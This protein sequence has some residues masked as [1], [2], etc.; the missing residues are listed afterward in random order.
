MQPLHLQRIC[1]FCICVIVICIHCICVIVISIHCIG[2]VWII[3]C[4]Q[5]YESKF[6]ITGIG[7]TGNW[8]YHSR[9]IFPCHWRL[10]PYLVHQ[11]TCYIKRL[12]LWLL[13][14]GLLLLEY[15]LPY[16]KKFYNVCVAENGDDPEPDSIPPFTEYSLEELKVWPS[17]FER[18]LVLDNGPCNSKSTRLIN[19]S[20]QPI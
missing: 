8:I 10:V 9:T 7:F 16:F 13:N 3:F 5:L 4:T 11:I 14:T 15:I 19:S 12:Q 1:Q 20:L 2:P 18:L 6:R 17:V